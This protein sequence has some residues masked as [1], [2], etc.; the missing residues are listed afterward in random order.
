MHR[1]GIEVGVA[2]LGKLC[3]K[4]ATAQTTS[5]KTD[6]VS[7]TGLSSISKSKN[8]LYFT[9]SDIWILHRCCFAVRDEWKVVAHEI[10]HNFGK[11]YIRP[12]QLKE[13]YWPRKKKLAKNRRDSWL[14]LRYLPM[15][16]FLYSMLSIELNP[17][18]CRRYLYHEPVEQRIDQRLQSMHNQN[19][20]RQLS[21]FGYMSRR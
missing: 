18:R 19:D 5:G 10:G 3:D 7:G 1:T 9:F 17:M 12:M 4:D 16:W 15:Q 20:L 2:W 8:F 21:Y 11:S 6:Y 14:H 13:S